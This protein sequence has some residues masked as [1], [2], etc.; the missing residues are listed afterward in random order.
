[1]D[2][3]MSGI[4]VFLITQGDALL[5]AKLLGVTAPAFYQMAFKLS[6]LPTTEIC[7]IISNVTFPAYA[8]L[9][10]DARRLKAAYFKVLQLTSLVALPIS[11]LIFVLTEEITSA[12]LGSKWMSIVP[13]MRILSRPWRKRRRA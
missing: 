12:V 1:M 6:N 8:K 7:Q 13:V 11:G 4:L 2:S 9:Q 10:G 3:K 5:V